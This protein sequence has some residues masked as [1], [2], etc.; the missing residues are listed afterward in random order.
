[1][2]WW[3]LFQHLLVKK[4]TMQ[5]LLTSGQDW[6]QSVEKHSNLA[7]T[8]SLTGPTTVKIWGATSAVRAKCQL[9]ATTTIARRSI[10]SL[11][12]LDRLE[13]TTHSGQIL[14]RK[15]LQGS[16]Q[17]AATSTLQR[18]RRSWT[19][20]TPHKCLAIQTT[21]NLTVEKP[22]LMNLEL[23]VMA[24]VMQWIGAQALSTAI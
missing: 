3:T 2:P 20:P 15:A 4:K 24:R 10:S 19:D 8:K 14:H 9:E 1:M 5:L 18:R 13:A 7:A 23:G 11:L 21:P 6:P 16:I 12:E 22:S 17:I